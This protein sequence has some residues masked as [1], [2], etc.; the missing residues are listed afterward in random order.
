M[1]KWNIRIFSKFQTL[2]TG[3]FFQLLR[4]IEIILQI[5]INY[6]IDSEKNILVCRV[7]Y[8]LKVAPVFE[9][10]CTIQNEL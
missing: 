5:H 9:F 6:F 3:K 7:N 10:V 1:R 4:S 8:T 2:S